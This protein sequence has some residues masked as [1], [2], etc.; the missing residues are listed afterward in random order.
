MPGCDTQPW[1]KSLIL[2]CHDYSNCNFSFSF[3]SNRHKLPWTLTRYYFIY[4]QQILTF[5]RVRV[6]QRVRKWDRVKTR[7]R[8]ICP[9]SSAASA[10]HLETTQ[11]FFFLSV[12]NNLFSLHYS[13]IP[14]LHIYNFFHACIQLPN[15]MKNSPIWPSKSISNFGMP[16]LCPSNDTTA[17]LL[18]IYL[19]YN[20][21]LTSRIVRN[22]K[23]VLL[24]L[25][26]LFS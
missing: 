17:L 2:S 24:D 22:T 18:E 15:L 11:H 26:I 5:N 21:L 10:P 3:S 4:K 12:C 16:P 1:K 20:F 25:L 7:P 14:A 19:K 23:V 8:R 13:L 6:T 9:H